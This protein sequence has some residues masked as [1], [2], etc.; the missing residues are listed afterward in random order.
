MYN[1]NMSK[2]YP[3]YDKCQCYFC[4]AK[5][6]FKNNSK[7]RSII[8][9][10][11][12]QERR[13]G[14]DNSPWN[15][16]PVCSTHHSLIHEGYIKVHGWFYSTKG[17]VLMWEDHLGNTHYGRPSKPFVVYPQEIHRLDE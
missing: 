2:V 8:E 17:W 1:R 12:I 4:D 10:H 3:T 14:G 6:E 16:V 11:H 9:L 15:L 7:C 5:K 13:H